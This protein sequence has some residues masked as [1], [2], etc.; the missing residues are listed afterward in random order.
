[1]AFLG[2]LLYVSQAAL[3]FL[4]NIELVSTLVLTYTLVLGRRA[5]FPVYVF[6]LLE[7]VTYGFGLWWFMYLYVWA[8]LY[9]AVRLLRRNTGA[10]VW[11][12]VSGFYGLSFGALCTIPYLLAGGPG[13]AFAYWT[14]GL[15]FDLLHCAGNF[16]ATLVLYRPFMTALQYVKRQAGL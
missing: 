10:L 8:V 13:A 7:G 6:V 12:A 14:S 15:S 4:P 5:L 3:S 11:A 9:L 16:A 2:A 1:M